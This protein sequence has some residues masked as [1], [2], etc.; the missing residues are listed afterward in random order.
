M[1]LRSRY[2]FN[3]IKAMDLRNTSE[4]IT[5][6]LDLAKLD[7]ASA[8]IKLGSCYENGCGVPKDYEQ[9]FSWYKKAAIQYNPIAQH[10]LGVMYYNGKGVS[11]DQEQAIYWWTKAAEQGN[12][13]AKESLEALQTISNAEQGDPVAQH[14]LGAMY[15]WGRLV[16][17]NHEKAL[18]WYIKAAEQGDARMQ[19]SLGLRYRAGKNVPQSDEQ[20]VFWFKKAAEQGLLI[21]QKHLDKK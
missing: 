1:I 18:Y 19:H 8:Q 15:S 13:F 9:S 6:L 3:W 5:N 12:T 2:L 11:A 17:Q 7:D 10:F 14:E 4:Y 21:A 16:S 20:A